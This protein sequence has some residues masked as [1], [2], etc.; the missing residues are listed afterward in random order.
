MEGGILAVSGAMV[1]GLTME[2]SLLGVVFD[3]SAAAA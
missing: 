1:E 3:M 2:F